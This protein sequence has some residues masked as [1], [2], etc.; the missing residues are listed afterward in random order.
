MLYT[1][2]MLC[3]PEADAAAPAVEVAPL[4]GLLKR[5]AALAGAGRSGVSDGP[6]LPFPDRH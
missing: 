2:T 4:G 5:V 6:G 3:L 1:L